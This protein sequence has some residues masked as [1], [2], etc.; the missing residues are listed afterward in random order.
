[1][2]KIKDILCKLFGLKQK[3]VEQVNPTKELFYYGNPLVFSITGIENNELIILMPE[4][5]FEQWLPAFQDSPLMKRTKERTNLFIHERRLDFDKIASENEIMDFDI[6]HGLNRILDVEVLQPDHYDP[7]CGFLIQLKH[8]LLN[9]EKT[10][11]LIPVLNI[12]NQ[13][14]SLERLPRDNKSECYF[15][16]RIDEDN[17]GAFN[18][19]PAF[20]DGVTVNTRPDLSYRVLNWD[21][22]EFVDD[23]VRPEGGYPANMDPVHFDVNPLSFGTKTLDEIQVQPRSDEL[24]QFNYVPELVTHLDITKPDT[25]TIVLPRNKHVFFPHYFYPITGD[26]D[27]TE[28]MT[29]LMQSFFDRDENGHATTKS[30]VA[31]IALMDEKDYQELETK[32]L[33]KHDD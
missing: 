16:G 29:S 22:F 23:R 7:R 10:Y 4:G 9:D 20:L 31:C 13:I 17:S 15:L 19:R 32:R 21:S 30:I 18:Y 1:M 2:K 8:T 27:I 24:G 14:V 26:Q 33:S 12:D 28:A 5:N 6:K 11:T 25:E 3:K